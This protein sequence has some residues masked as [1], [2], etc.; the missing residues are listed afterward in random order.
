LGNLKE[1]LELIIVDNIGFIILKLAFV[2]L[3]TNPALAAIPPR[4][5]V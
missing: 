5:T 4:M 1:L 3:F 2:P